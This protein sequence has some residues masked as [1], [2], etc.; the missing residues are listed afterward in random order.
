MESLYDP[1]FGAAAAAA[2]AGLGFLIVKFFFQPRA[3]KKSLAR[4]RRRSLETLKSLLGVSGDAFS[5]QNKRA[6][7]LLAKV[8]ENHPGL[9]TTDET[10]RSLGFDEIFHRAYDD[11]QPEEMELFQLIRGTTMTSLYETN[12]KVYEWIEGNSA[13]LTADKTDKVMNDL[14]EDLTALRR[15]LRAW[16]DKYSVWIPVKESRSIVYLADEKKHGTGFPRRLEQ[17]LDA[18]L[19]KPA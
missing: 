8:R 13:F 9:V 10:G 3:E 14:A 18:A 1:L 5:T 15:H 11:L 16:L 12:K 7:T 6:R 17:S 19:T 2:F 4:R